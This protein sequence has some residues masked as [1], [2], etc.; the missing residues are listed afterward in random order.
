MRGAISGTSLRRHIALT[1]LPPSEESLQR[2]LIPILEDAFGL[3]V[4]TTDAVPL[5][6]GAYNPDRH[7]YHSTALLE[8]LARQKQPEWERLLGI[9]DVDLYTPDLN[10]VFGEADAARGVAVFSVARLHTADRDR[11]VH[12]AA[13]EAIHEVAH[14]YGLA[15]CDNT[16]CV[17]WFSNTLQETDRK[18]TRFCRAHTEALR[19]AMGLT[20]DSVRR[21]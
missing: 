18:G 9:T 14:T 19:R 12:R 2:L 13:T 1:L 4:V 6:S 5:P 7:Q 16:R 10:F 21:S 11:F 17:M 20:G 15:H 3:A 8:V